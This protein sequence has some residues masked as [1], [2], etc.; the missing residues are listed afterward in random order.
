VN[1]EPTG[2]ANYI[3]A[4]SLT[5]N[6]PITV[7][8]TPSGWTDN[9]DNL[10]FVFWFNT[11]PALPYPHDVAPGSSLGGFTIASIGS[12]STLLTA[13]IV[14][15]DHSLDAP[16]PLSPPLSVAAPATPAVPEPSS[17]A[18]ILLPIIFVIFYKHWSTSS[19]LIKCTSDW[20]VQLINTNHSN[21]T[22]SL[23]HA[24]FGITCNTF[25]VGRVFV[26]CNWLGTILGFSLRSPGL[27]LTGTHDPHFS[28]DTAVPLFALPGECSTSL[29]TNKEP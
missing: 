10:T 22:L 20:R 13:G 25:Y 16:G 12:V 3:A 4:F 1:D 5:V 24:V 17:F 23:T 21:Q 2:S 26:L 7:T 8:G 11:D 18:L 14:S 19:T 9:T 28:M 27:A 29:A 15:W 6:A